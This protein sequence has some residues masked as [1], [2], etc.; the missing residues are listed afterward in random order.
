MLFGLLSVSLGTVLNVVLIFLVVYLLARAATR[1]LLRLDDVIDD[2]QEVWARLG[3]LCKEIQLEKI[4]N[5]CYKI[6]AIN[7]DEAL[8]AI[9]LLVDQSTD[10]RAV[11]EMLRPNFLYQLPKRLTANEDRASVIKA[12]LDDAVTRKEILA[13]VAKDKAAAL[14]GQ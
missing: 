6:S 2:R 13:A 10:E 3:G 5:I 1:K 14:T 11:M 9:R 4:A 12:V 8:Q 7:V